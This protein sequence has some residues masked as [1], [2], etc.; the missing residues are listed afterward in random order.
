MKLNAL[1]DIISE[2]L[3][4]PIFSEGISAAKGFLVQSDPRFGFIMKAKGRSEYH[5]SAMP[6]LEV[7]FKDSFMF[8]ISVG[9]ENLEI[10]AGKFILNQDSIWL[11]ERKKVQ[12]G[13]T[14]IPVR[15]IK[16]ISITM[17]A[18]EQL[19]RGRV[20]DFLDKL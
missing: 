14:K 20:S 11:F 12:D 2:R 10:Q 17:P 1:I 18:Q 13:A 9:N 5:H 19:Q 8:S 6:Y 4:E 3:Q 7:S 16:T 15:D